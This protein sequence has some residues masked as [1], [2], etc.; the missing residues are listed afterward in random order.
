MILGDRVFFACWAYMKVLL[1]TELALFNI[2]YIS[3]GAQD[4]FRQ[5]SAGPVKMSDIPIHPLLNNH[6]QNEH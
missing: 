3:L 5:S 2:F 4:M 1:H 6:A